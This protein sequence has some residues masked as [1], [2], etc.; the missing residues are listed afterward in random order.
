MIVIPKSCIW[1]VFCTLEQFVI[2]LYY[3]TSWDR[4]PVKHLVSYTLLLVRQERK[5]WLSRNLTPHT[6]E[7]NQWLVLWV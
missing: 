5:G 3:N 1:E 4:F 6:Y 2:C 7:K